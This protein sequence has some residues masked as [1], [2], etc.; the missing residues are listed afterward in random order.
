MREDANDAHL[1]STLSQAM[2]SLEIGIGVVA[3]ELPVLTPVFDET[4]LIS[5]GT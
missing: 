3:R 4:D 1:H 5:R 2:W